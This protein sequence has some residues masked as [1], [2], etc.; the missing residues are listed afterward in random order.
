[1]SN[2]DVVEREQ[3][4]PLNAAYFNALVQGL[5]GIADLCALLAQ[6]CNASDNVL[7]FH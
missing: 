5:D 2:F 4:S 3:L 1:M 6:S 7:S